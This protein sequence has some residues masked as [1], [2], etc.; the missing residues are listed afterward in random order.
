MRRQTI[1]LLAVGT[2]LALLP[3]V[4]SSY[5]VSVLTQALIFSGFAMGLDLLIGY[6][7]MQTLGHAAFFGLAGYGAALAITLQGI[8]PWL[9]AA[10]GIS[11]SLVIAV[12]FAPLAV[13]FRGL[14]FLTVTLAFGQVAWGLATRW[15]SFTG[16]ENGIPGIAR[17]AFIWNLDTV[18]GFYLLTVLVVV[19]VTFLLIQFAFSAVG[20]S[21]LGVGGSDTR[22]AALGYN[23]Q[24]RRTVAFV[25]A[26]LVGA[27]YGTLN[28]FFNKF[29][30][31][32]SLDWR[33]SAQM[34]LAVIV[35]GAGSLWGPFIAGGALHILK[36]SLVGETQRWPMVLGF[37]YILSVIFLPGGLASI[38]ARLR[39]VFAGRRSGV[40]PDEERP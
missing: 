27:F 28:A 36:T 5:W 32:G 20:M 37:L 17:P 29:I 21:L 12:L 14:T 38:P 10:I 13:R 3:L 26:A 35:G 23:V 7:R 8:N 11:I 6:T 34:L 31:P 39:G 24:T 15:T 1:T 33:L 30:G 18:V 19:I 2:G 22:M 40:A 4:L 9:A 25:V 16:G